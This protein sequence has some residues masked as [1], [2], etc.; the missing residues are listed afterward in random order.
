MHDEE[1]FDRL[2]THGRATPPP[3]SAAL[4][5]R[6][7][8]DR[9]TQPVAFRSRPVIGLGVALPSAAVAAAVL[10]LVL[11]TFG[12]SGSPDT[13]LVQEASNARL[14]D[15]GKVSVLRAG[16]R[17][18]DDRIIVTDEDG[19]AVVGYTTVGPNS[20]AVVDDG[21]LVL[22]MGVATA[23]PS[24]TTTTSTPPTTTT[25]STPTTPT[26]LATQAAV[27]PAPT[28]P[29]PPAA[30]APAPAPAP[31]T[32]TVPAAGPASR[33]DMAPT[34]R[35]EAARTPRGIVFFR[36]S[37]YDGPD[38]G[39]YVVRRIQDGS[40]AFRALDQETLQGGD[41]VAPPPPTRY[42]LLVL[43]TNRQIVARSTIAE[44]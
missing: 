7:T 3:P 34:I 41:R 1:L 9:L 10:G 32:T 6:L 22:V 36:W 14:I 20:R 18:A 8:G 4:A 30:P 44:V 25:T 31:S 23:T 2:E 11:V 17:V 39:A 15:D 21:R 38:F 43:D 42:V 29:V 33:P 12:G 40:M 24:T 28:T 13:V 35:S 27:R 16:Q 19:Y 26:T 37:R 5:A